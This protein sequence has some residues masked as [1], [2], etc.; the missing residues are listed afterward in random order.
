MTASGDARSEDAAARPEPT[1]GGATADADT[2]ACR[3]PSELDLA[4]LEKAAERAGLGRLDA[5]IVPPDRRRDR[6]F[7]WSRTSLRVSERVLERLAPRDACV[8]LLNTVLLE[9]RRR[10]LASILVLLWFVAV[11]LFMAAT[12]LSEDVLNPFSVAAALGLV[13]LLLAGPICWAASAHAADDDTV[14]WLGD[15]DTLCHA[16][17]SMNQ[18]KLQLAGRTLPARPDLHRRAERL[19]EKHQL[20]LAPEDRTVPSL[21]RRGP[22]VLA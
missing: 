21:Q 1:S 16:L 11:P 18:D 10:K 15:A 20:R 2:E 13:A 17:N 14:S 5:E 3:L 6:W 4:P 9:R 19:V 12:L 22:D 8:L 7:E